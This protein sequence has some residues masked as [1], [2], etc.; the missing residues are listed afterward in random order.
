MSGKGVGAAMFMA[1]SKT[2]LKNLLLTGNNLTLSDIMAH[3]NNQLKADN[4][5]RM[6]V[7][8]FIGLL[9]IRTGLFEYVNGGHNP[10]LVYE[11]DKGAFRYLDVEANFVLAGR[12]N[13]AYESQSIILKPGDGLFLYTDGVTE[14]MNDK[15]ELYGEER[16]LSYLN[17]SSN[18]NNPRDLIEDISKTIVYFV[19]DAEQSDD[20][21]MLG[22]TYWGPSGET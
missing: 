14:A 15:D 12:K 8:V 3:A 10:S 6:F 9:D 5:A 13:I 4:T 7:T 16:L 1:I 11:K 21:T 2:I 17:K 20:I 18:A 22:L 19:G